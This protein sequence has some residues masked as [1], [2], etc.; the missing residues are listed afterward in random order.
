MYFSKKDKIKH[1]ALI[2]RKLKCFNS[3]FEVYFDHL[4]LSNNNEVNDFLIVKPKVLLEDKVVGICVLPIVNKKFC[5]MKGWRHQ[6]EDYIYQA[7]A[8]FCEINETPNET[9]LREL[10]EETSL[11]CDFKDLVSLGY[12]LPD[13]GLIEGRV[14]IFLAKNCH[15]KDSNII[16]EIG[17]GEKV[18]F[19]KNKFISLLA[20]SNNI[21]GSTL[22]ASYRALHYISE[23]KF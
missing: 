23:N 22:V 19:D 6:F 14:A 8:G 12:Y 5:L 1:Y 16:N 21:G 3:K 11:Y 2:K 17:T 4:K 13:A 18:F 20:N 7:P 15:L 10:F 9:A